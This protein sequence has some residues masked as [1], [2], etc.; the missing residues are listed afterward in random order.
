MKPLTIA[1][2]GN[3]KSTNRYHLPFVLQLTEQF[4][5]KTIYARHADSTWARVPGVHYTTDVT[6]IYDDPEIQLVVITT[7]ASSH[8]ELAKTALNHDKH[9]LLEKPFT[10]TTA[11]A[12]TLFALAKAKGLFL[13]CYTNRRFDSDWLT[14]QAVIASDKLGE[15][16]E[17]DSAF[18]YYRPEVP[19]NQRYSAANSF[20]YGHGTHTLD[21]VVGYFGAPDTTRYDVRQLNGSGHMNDDFTVDLYYG[22]LKVCVQSSYYRLTSRPSFAVYGKCGSFIKQT[23]DRQEYDLKHW[24]LPDHADFGLDRPEDY[25]TLT[26]MDDQGQYHQEKV[27][28]VPGDYGRVY[29]GVYASIVEGAPKVTADDETLLVMRMLETG[30]KN[31]H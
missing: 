13:Q 24:Y 4:V 16:T 27:Q 10:E 26:Y 25:G 31:L 30:V 23:T 19:D 3:G 1:Y 18:D 20:L 28:T 17:L 6:D 7:P 22:A 12:E 5:V 11:Q 9:V 2:I 29:R 14:V 15:L 21:Q 8:F